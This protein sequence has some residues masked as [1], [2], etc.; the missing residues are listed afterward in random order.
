MKKATVT[1]LLS[2]L[3]LAASATHNMASDISY[4]HM[5]GN[6]FKIT[7]RTFTNTDPA[8]TQVE[9]CDIVIYFGDGD[10]AMAPRINGPAFLCPTA[11]GEP[12]STFIKK[13]VYEITHTY[14]GYGVYTVTVEDP[15]RVD[16]ICNIP[17][18]VDA[19]FYI[20]AEIKFNVFSATNSSPD[21]TGIPMVADTVGI[22]SYYTPALTETDGDSLSYELFTPMANGMPIPGYTLPANSIDFSINPLTGLVTWN[23]PTT[24][25]NYVYAIKITEWKT[26]AGVAYNIGTTMQEVWNQGTAY[27]DIA[28]QKLSLLKVYP[29]PSSG[30]VH[31]SVPETFAK[32]SYSIE[33]FN[34]MGQYITKPAVSGSGTVIVNNLSK[35]TYF[36]CLKN[37]GTTI[38]RGTFIVSDNSI[39]T[40]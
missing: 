32:E 1:V 37:T 31:F 21:Y 20:K 28:E 40:E 36:F 22:A 10:S 19:S 11:D 17:N 14:P 7:V 39:Y 29:N 25:C 6:T 8:T 26:V 9:R 18:S 15:N 35:G 38:G 4:T 33:I 27:T 3:V 23:V 30:T 5:G 16:G 12:V 24:I 2:L 34:S 13:N